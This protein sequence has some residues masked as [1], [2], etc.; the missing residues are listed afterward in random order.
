MILDVFKELSPGNIL[1]YHE[2][3]AWRWNDLIPFGQCTKKN[4]YSLMMWGWRNSLR[5]WISLRILSAISKSH[6][7]ARWIIFT[8]TWM[9][10]INGQL[11]K[12]YALWPR[13][14]PLKASE[15]AIMV[16]L[17]DDPPK[18][19]LPERLLQLVLPDSLYSNVFSGSGHP[20]FYVQPNNV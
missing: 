18:R 3:I 20:F 1:H 16:Y 7:F 15:T 10:R 12:P 13:G 5:I 8:A 19:S 6:T 17:T 11:R 2:D 9:I 4:P 14:P